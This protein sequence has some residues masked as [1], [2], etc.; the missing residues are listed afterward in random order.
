VLPSSL[1]LPV[2]P[3]AALKRNIHACPSTLLPPSILQRA[4]KLPRQRVVLSQL[5]PQQ[6]EQQQRSRNC[7]VP[8]TTNTEHQHLLQLALVSCSRAACPRRRQAGPRL[9]VLRRSSCGLRDGRRS[10]YR[11]LD[12]RGV[13]NRTW[14]LMGGYRCGFEGCA[15][16]AGFLLRWRVNLSAAA[17]PFRCCKLRQ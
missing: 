6:Q 11:R 2:E 15:V 7:N 4:A 14:E 13:R 3:R 5:P 1:T 10:G 9:C 8:S 12:R 16:A 17:A